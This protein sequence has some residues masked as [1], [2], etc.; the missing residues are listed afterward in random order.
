MVANR[1]CDFNILCGSGA[2]IVT[3]KKIAF[4]LLFICVL[5]LTGCKK[6]D[7]IY[8]AE[9]VSWGSTREDV[10]AAYGNS[11]IVISGV[12]FLTYTDSFVFEPYRDTFE[13]YPGTAMFLLDDNG[14]LVS[15]S[16]QIPIEL[17]YGDSEATVGFL[18][19]LLGASAEEYYGTEAD[20]VNDNSDDGIYSEQWS[21]E[22]G[23]TI[24]GYIILV[25]RM[26]SNVH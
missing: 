6:K 21:S 18:Y 25:L 19:N 5:F 9:K 26:T 10:I 23:D 7:G 17:D 4:F 11:S 15:V 20:V 2:L 24:I 12:D 22:K 13:D 1:L 8:V 3:Q 16:L 14:E